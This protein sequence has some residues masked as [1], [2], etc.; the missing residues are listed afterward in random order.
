[1]RGIP[2]PLL[3]CHMSIAG[4]LHK[5]LLTAQAHGCDTVQLFTASPNCWPVKPLPARRAVSRF[6]KF[7]T[8]NTN[9]WS[10]RDL[11]AEETRTFRRTLRQTGLRFPMAHDCY[12]INLASPDKALW[13]KSIEAFV[14]ELQRAEALGLRYLVMHP[15]S[16]V[17]GDE[18]AGLVR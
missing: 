12:L 1:S 8:K 3:G 7:L 16:P 14:V 10:A 15:G 6:G 5:A 11:T 18:K 17:D 2:M 4:G 13:R 9:P